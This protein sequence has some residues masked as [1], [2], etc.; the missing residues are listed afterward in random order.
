MRPRKSG[1][2]AFRYPAGSWVLGAGYSWVQGIPGTPGDIRDPGRPGPRVSWTRDPGK[3]RSLFGAYTM[4]RNSASGPAG[5]G[6]RLALPAWRCSATFLYF[7]GFSGSHGGGLGGP[8]GPGKPSKMWGASATTYRLEEVFGPL[9][10]PGPPK[11]GD[12]S[13]FFKFKTYFSNK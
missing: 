1:Q 9:G 5:A 12:C 10:P 6:P 7:S 3:P 4:L 11:T 8:G 13:S 2:T